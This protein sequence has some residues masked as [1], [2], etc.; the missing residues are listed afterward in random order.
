MDV[1]EVLVNGADLKKV[2]KSAL[3]LVAARP[4]A[5][6]VFWPALLRS[7]AGTIINSQ[8]GVLEKAVED[9]M[10]GRQLREVIWTFVAAVQSQHF[11]S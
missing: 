9:G 5:F 11:N 1:I 10:G 6:T 3:K 2:R 4:R 7:N 8:V